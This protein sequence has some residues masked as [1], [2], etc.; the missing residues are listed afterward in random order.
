MLCQVPQLVENY[1]TGSADGISF[2]FL[3]V[4]FIGDLSN[5]FGAIWARLVPTVIALA[6]YFCIADSV[7]I[8]QCI[9]YKKYVWKKQVERPESPEEDVQRPLLGRRPSSN[10]GLPG[11]RRGSLAS[12]KCRGSMLEP[13]TLHSISEDRD[14][15]KPWVRN[16]LCV[17]AVCAIGSAGWAI[18]W[19]IG[20]WKP[21]TQDNERGSNS[22]PISALIL[23]YVSALCYLGSVGSSISN[24]SR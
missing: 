22:E 1:R 16:G 21:I 23:G 12:H 15:V 20:A 2:A 18:A 8:V 17:L 4:W 11:S 6:I 9:Y 24:V 10:I 14:S 19:R 5:L 7:L 13:S 3:A